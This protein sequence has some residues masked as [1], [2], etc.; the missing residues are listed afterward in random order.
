GLNAAPAVSRTMPDN[1]GSFADRTGRLTR[2]GDI[3]QAVTAV[4]NLQ[5][6]TAFLSRPPCGS[7]IA[8]AVGKGGPAKPR[9]AARNAETSM[10][11]TVLQRKNMVESQVRP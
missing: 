11:D 2:S 1:N 5:C 9:K 7:R 8:I 6:A 3:L 4:R 10:A